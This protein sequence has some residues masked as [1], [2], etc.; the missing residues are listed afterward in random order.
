MESIPEDNRFLD[1]GSAARPGSRVPQYGTRADIGRCQPGGDAINIRERGSISPVRSKGVP[2]CN[3]RAAPG[4]E[5]TQRSR[6][7]SPD[8]PP[9]PSDTPASG[10]SYAEPPTTPPTCPARSEAVKHPA[11]PSHSHDPPSRP[12]QDQSDPPLP[13]RYDLAADQ[14]K[15]T[16]D[17][18]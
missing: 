8:S 6:V 1:R 2:V 12:R 5:T 3:E 14:L 17:R 4:S 11:R 7:T 16:P 13:R 15:H 10:S 9:G 18:E